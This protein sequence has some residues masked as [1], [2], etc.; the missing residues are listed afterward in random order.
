MVAGANRILLDVTDLVSLMLLRER[1][2]GIPRVIAHCLAELLDKEPN[3]VPVF[4]SRISRAFSRID[5]SLLLARDLDYLRKLNPAPG[6]NLRRLRA[7]LG[8]LRSGRIVPEADDTLLLLG[9]GWGFPRRHDLL[10]GPRSPA[11]RVAWFC[12]DLIPLLHPQFAMNAVAFGEAYR[13]W[14]DAALSRGHQF[15]CASR[16]VET[17]LRDYADSQ[18]VAVDVS[19]VPLAHEFK[20]VAGPVRDSVSRLAARRTALCVSSIGLRKNQIA[21]IRAWDRLRTE[22][23]DGIPT[24][25]LA[26]DIIDGAEIEAFLQRTDSV[27]GKVELLGPVSEPELA[28]LYEMCDF[29]IFPSLNEGWGLPVGESLW[30]AKPCVSSNLSSMPEVGADHVAYFD[31]RDEAAMEAALREAVLGKFAALPPPRGRLRTWRHVA[32]DLLGT[33][34]R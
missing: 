33:L 10:F 3:V 18:D 25:V 8:V 1:P 4:F 32:D 14:L 15:I 27:G 31:P 12:H 23:G 34:S 28:R 13:K 30:M 26:G 9:A 24:L 29:T 20:P 7:Y 16:Y 2:N 19:I 5:G 11:C 21:L 6:H 17:E 22:F